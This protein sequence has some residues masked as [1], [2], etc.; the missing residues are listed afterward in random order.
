MSPRVYDEMWI[1]LAGA[2]ESEVILIEEL[3][4][5]LESRRKQYATSLSVQSDFTPTVLGHVFPELF[6]ESMIASVFDI[7]ALHPES[8]EQIFR[9]LQ[10]L[11]TRVTQA[12]GRREIELTTCPGRFSRCVRQ[13]IS[14]SGTA[15]QMTKL[16][17]TT[18][19]E[20]PT[21]VVVTNPLC[22]MLE[23]S[24]SIV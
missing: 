10:V 2:D 12:T 23:T 14:S 9:A 22:A 13:V 8:A 15:V 7:I 18:G 11:R 19:Q 24:R 16:R 21:G 6:Q 1:W 5:T 4:L 3:F 17:R 20:L